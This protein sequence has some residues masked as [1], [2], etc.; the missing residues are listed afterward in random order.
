MF[1]A[2]VSPYKLFCF[3]SRPTS[4]TRRSNRYLRSVACTLIRAL[5]VVLA[6]AG[7]PSLTF[8]SCTTPKNPIEAENCLPGTPSS[9]WYING[10]GSPN[11]VGFATD[12]SVN[13][14]QTIS[15]KV[16]TNAT[17]WRMDIYRLGYYQGNGSRFVATVLPSAP[18]PQVQPA[19][20][21]DS[22]TGLV[23]CGD[24]AVSG[25]WVV[26]STATSGIYFGRLIRLDTSEA[27]P[28]VFVVRNDASHSD[29]LVQTSDQTWHAYNDYGGNSLYTGNPPVH[30]RDANDS[31]AGSERL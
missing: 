8:G 6:F 5:L 3:L 16:S 15:F 28:V 30:F 19:C 31:L 2:R 13:A 24:W 10:A 9:Q 23:D 29:I 1:L 26:P 11:I 18:L 25:S 4:V 22:T 14:G 21:S 12:I 27:S 20:I 17:S 7:V